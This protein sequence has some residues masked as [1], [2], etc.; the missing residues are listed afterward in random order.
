MGNVVSQ[1]GKPI[2][3]FLR[4]LSSTQKRYTTTD[5]ELLVIVETLKQFKTMLKGQ[6]MVVH[7]DHQNLT[8]DYM[9]SSC[10]A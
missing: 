8:Y 10:C 7:T 3:F 9:E 2:A 5:K 6:D 1:K 4:K